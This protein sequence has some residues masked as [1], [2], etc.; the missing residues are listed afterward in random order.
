MKN[1]E[2]YRRTGK[3]CEGMKIR[4]GLTKIIEKK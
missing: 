2:E 1:S 3:I 4:E